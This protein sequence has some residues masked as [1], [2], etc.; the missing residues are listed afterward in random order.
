VEIMRTWISEG[1]VGPD[2]LVWREGWRDWRGASEVF[3]RLV[4]GT[5]PRGADL[6]VPDTPVRLPGRGSAH[7]SVGRRRS[8]RSNQV[9]LIVM[10][11]AA[12][13]ALF[14]VFLYVITRGT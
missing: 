3:P 4:A 14:G 5:S 13:V 7:L 6:F 9:F 11:L 12:V 2:A 10:L 1:R 8:S